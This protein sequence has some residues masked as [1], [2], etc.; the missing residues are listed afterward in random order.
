MSSLPLWL[1][2]VV[3]IKGIDHLT[4][5]CKE[6]E[7]WYNNWRP[8]MTLDGFR[9]DDV[10]YNNKLNKPESDA[11]TVPCNIKKHFFKQT[12]ITAYRLTKAA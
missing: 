7:L 12:R 11:K 5:L 10:Y 9:P 6:F 8:H 1:K 3:L 2:R 4:Y